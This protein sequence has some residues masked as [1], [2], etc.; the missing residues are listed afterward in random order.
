MTMPSRV[1][2]RRNASA[3][4]PLAVGPAMS[5]S[6]GFFE[7]DLI[8]A[9]LIAADRLSRGDISAAAD[10]LRAAGIEPGAPSWVEEGSA[11]DL[12]LAAGAGDTRRVLER[13]IEGVDVVV[14]PAA[15]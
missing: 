2:A 14:Q 12:P 7:A 1:S 4:L 8:I 13:L 6:G 9:T 11:C 10:A 15:G 5:A 3:D